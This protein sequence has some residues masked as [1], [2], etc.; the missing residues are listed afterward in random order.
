MFDFTSLLADASI[1]F[2]LGLFLGFVAAWIVLSKTKKE[3]H[4]EMLEILKQKND[5]IAQKDTIIAQKEREN[6]CQADIFSR[7]MAN[8]DLLNKFFSSQPKNQKNT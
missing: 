4:A 1:H 2:V 6:E 3:N 8:L 5:I 7:Y